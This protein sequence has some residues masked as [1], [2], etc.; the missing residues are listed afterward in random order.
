MSKSTNKEHFHC[1]TAQAKQ[2]EKTV[3]KQLKIQKIKTDLKEQNCSTLNFF[4]AYL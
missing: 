4:A 1:Q 2:N 3:R